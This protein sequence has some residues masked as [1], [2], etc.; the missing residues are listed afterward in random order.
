MQY[1][2]FIQHFWAPSW[3]RP[4]GPSLSDSHAVESAERRP[5]TLTIPMP[6]ANPEWRSVA[7]MHFGGVYAMRT[8]DFTQGE[9]AA[10]VQEANRLCLSLLL[11]VRE[12]TTDPGDLT[13]LLV[14][15]DI[16]SLASDLG[17][18]PDTTSW[19]VNVRAAFDSENKAAQSLWEAWAPRLYAA[20]CFAMPGEPP[21]SLATLDGNPDDVVTLEHD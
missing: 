1:E 4:F 20:L 21:R 14:P 9:E 12:A 16:G 11:K 8:T 2:D 17:L 3:Q 13:W 10:F 19:A 5:G 18:D 15:A 6:I 7:S